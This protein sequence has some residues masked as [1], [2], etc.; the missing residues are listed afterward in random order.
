[1]RTSAPY[2]ERITSSN[3]RPSAS[4]DHEHVDT[5]QRSGSTRRGVSAAARSWTFWNAIDDAL[6][7]I[8][9][10]EGISGPAS[11]TVICMSCSRESCLRFCE[12]DSGAAT[13]AVRTIRNVVPNPIRVRKPATL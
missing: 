11:V 2:P 5:A 13:L 6:E 9:R 10:I 3:V 4:L 8:D 12:P 7:D 1:M